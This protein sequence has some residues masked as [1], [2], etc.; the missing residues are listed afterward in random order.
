MKKL[1]KSLR[2][3]ALGAGEEVLVDIAYEKP[4]ESTLDY[5]VRT[6]QRQPSTRASKANHQQAMYGNSAQASASGAVINRRPTP[7][8]L[9]RVPSKKYASVGYNVSSTTSSVASNKPIAK[10]KQIS[11]T[12]P[13]PAIMQELYHKVLV[14]GY[15]LKV[16]REHNGIYS[17][18]V[19][20]PSGRVGS[21]TIYTLGPEGPSRIPATFQQ[22]DQ[23]RVNRLG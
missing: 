6:G 11:N 20:N 22:R 10:P 19:S 18:A 21:N 16:L 9:R 1:I 8:P 5:L 3:F 14:K 17:I 2:I 7:P 12:A 4:K 15:G 23:M 13:I